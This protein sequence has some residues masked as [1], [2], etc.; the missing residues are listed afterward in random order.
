MTRKFQI[1]SLSV[2]VVFVFNCNLS[3][4]ET[5]QEAVEQAIATNPNVRSVAHN[6]LG[7]NQEV[8]QA[9]SGYFPKVDVMFGAGK[10]FV[11]EPLDDDLDPLE[12]SLTIRQNIFAGLSTKREV[13]RQKARVRSQAYI[14]RSS[15]ENIAL[16]T[17]Q[18]YLSVL[19]HTAIFDLA[20]ENLLLHQRISDQIRLRSES[21]VGSQA[22]MTQIQSRLSLAESNKIIAEQNLADANTNYL[23]VIGELPEDLSEPEFDSTFLPENEEDAQAVAIK[24]HPTLQSANEDL[25]ARKSQDLVAESPFMPVLD[26]ELDSTYE[27]E[28][29][30]STERRE[31]ILAM[32]RLRYNLFNG[33]KDH[34]RKKETTEMIYEAREIRNNTQ[35]QVVESMRLSWQSYSATLKRLSHLEKR[36]KFATATAE[37]YT[38]QWNIGKRTLLDV[39]DAEAERIDSEQQRLV[40]HYDNLYARYRI[41]NASGQLVHGLGLE[42]PEE[43]QIEDEDEREK[44]KEEE[45]GAS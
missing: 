29:D 41:L 17:T 27:E 10:D 37:S 18:V 15:S 8:R 14:V 5:I 7:R 23:A 39:L 42:W 11:N 32:L 20:E 35:R 43:A 28:T 25:E 38:E 40:A 2:I 26:F 22:D 33:W 24:K 31:N 3:T 45:E 6:R 21:G 12:A 44:E 19:R 9:K 16:S 4:G 36:V 13:E 1:L 34:A 30:Y